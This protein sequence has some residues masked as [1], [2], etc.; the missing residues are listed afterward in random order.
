MHR[1][2]NKKDELLLLSRKNTETLVEQRRTKK[3]RN[4][5]I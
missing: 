4:S 3:T 1:P 5:R 2:K